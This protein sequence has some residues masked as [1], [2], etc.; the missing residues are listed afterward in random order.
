V[1]RRVP[2]LIWVLRGL[3]AIGVAR[4]LLHST[5]YITDLTG[6][7]SREWNATLTAKILGGL[8]AALA[9][10][11]AALLLLRR[12]PAGRGAPFAVGGT[13]L[14][15]GA[16]VMLSGYASGGQLGLPLGAA[17]TGAFLASLLLSGQRTTGGALSFGIVGL[18]SLVVV[19]RLFG[20]LT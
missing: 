11:W 5:I 3:V 18:F 12:R 14:C 20:E 19:G 8:A 1:T 15:A 2:W 17:L 16:T 6:P 9:V 13:C 10:V 4:I 7:G